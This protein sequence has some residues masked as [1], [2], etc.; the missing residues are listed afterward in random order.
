M[1]DSVESCGVRKLTGQ[2]AVKLHQEL[3]VDVV[4]L[5]GLAVRGPLVVLPQ[6]D[7]YCCKQ[8][9]VSLWVLVCSC[10]RASTSDASSPSTPAPSFSLQKGLKREQRRRILDR[11]QNCHGSQRETYFRISSTRTQKASR[12]PGYVP[13]VTVTR[14]LS[15]KIRVDGGVRLAM[16]R[17]RSSQNL[18]EI[19]DWWGG[20][21]A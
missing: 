17:I 15:T 7:T 12:R 16:S 19:L 20:F 2:E 13:I 8:T 4:A 9:P 3:Q 5:G 10:W 18:G 11:E 6:I 1:T 21:C 14:G